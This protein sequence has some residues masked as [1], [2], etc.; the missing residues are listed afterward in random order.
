MR[1]PLCRGRAA[2]ALSGG[3]AALTLALPLSTGRERAG[4]KLLVS[5]EVGAG[6]GEHIC[7]QPPPVP[8]P[9]GQQ[10]GSGVPV[11]AGHSPH[12]P[13]CE[14]CAPTGTGTWLLLAGG[15]CPAQG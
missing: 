7:S 2:F 9:W 14:V 12:G 1:L 6:R 15:V 10:E 5:T 13:T 11:K 8:G 3:P 4:E